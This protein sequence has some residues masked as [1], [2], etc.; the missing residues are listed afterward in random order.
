MWCSWDV[1]LRNKRL[2]S[3]LQILSCMNYSIIKLNDGIIFLFTLHFFSD[4]KK[5]RFPIIDISKSGKCLVTITQHVLN[6][7]A[8]DLAAWSVPLSL[9]HSSYPSNVSFAH[10]GLQGTV[11]N[12]TT[13]S[14]NFLGQ[15]VTLQVTP[16]KKKGTWE[17]LVKRMLAGVWTLQTHCEVLTKKKN[18]GRE[19]LTAAQERKKK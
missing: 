17:V 1:F 11:S 14:I 8:S 16:G 12:N 7:K 6:V 19:A 2:V 18:S 10:E 4:E 9:W 13:I 3:H 5:V 15:I